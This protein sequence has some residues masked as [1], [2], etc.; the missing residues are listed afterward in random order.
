MI[1]GKCYHDEC[2]DLNI[3]TNGDQCDNCKNLIDP[4]KLIE[5]ISKESNTTPELR[6][7]THLF[8]QLNKIQGNIEEFLNN[9]QLSEQATGL[10]NGLLKSGLHSRCITRDLEWGTPVPYN[11][12]SSLEPLK[13][14]VFYVWFDAPIG[15]LSI[16]KKEKPS[17]YD[18]LCSHD[19]DW[20]QFMAKDNV[21]FHTI[22]FPGTLL[23]TGKE[24]PLVTK[25]MA[26]DYLNY[27]GQK[28]SKSKGI[29]VFGNHVE[30]ISNKLGID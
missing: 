7:T 27:E 28:F 8:L 13:G 2:R 30:Q 17:D 11:Y 26:C 4:I 16:L 5:P 6:E 29:G 22:I 12:H 23:G 19:C 1:K 10:C 14:K 20:V 24:Y 9:V 15:Y 18:Y 21:P 25:I 3:E